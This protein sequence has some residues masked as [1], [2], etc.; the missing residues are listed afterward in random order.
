VSYID[1]HPTHY[2]WRPDVARLVRKYQARFP[3]QT[4]ANTYVWHPPYSPP[5]I[6]RRY[7]SQSVDF[8]GGGRVDG[9]YTGYRGKPLPREI[10]KRLFR[11]IWDDPEGPRIWW[12]IYWGRMWV[13]PAF[14]GRGWGPSPW[15]PP[16]SDPGHYKH[17]HCTF[18]D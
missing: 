8:W 1:Q 17:I 13:N 16:D 9:R 2:N 12:V 10:G 3:Y 7:D 5:A 11:E 14:G 15:G 6:T 18:E 4:F